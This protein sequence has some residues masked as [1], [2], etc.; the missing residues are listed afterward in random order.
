MSP[1]QQAGNQPRRVHLGAHMSIAGGC[2]NALTRGRDVGCDAVQLFTKNASQWK[3]K[4]LT[5][6]DIARF[7]ATLAAT[8][9]SP[10]V[11]MVHDSYLINLATA[12]PDLRVK[13]LTA[14]GE[15]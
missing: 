11:L 5:D 15:E 12:D 7:Q 3:A 8:G 2:Y 1:E 4:P 14:F 6:E 9:Y 10:D 13:S